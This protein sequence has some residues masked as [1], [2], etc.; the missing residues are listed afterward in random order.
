MRAL[1]GAI[2]L[3]VAYMYGPAHMSAHSDWITV[4][5]V[6]IALSL[7]TAEVV[8]GHERRS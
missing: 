8:S 5:F 4:W 3:C 7:I 1:A 2:M 6:S